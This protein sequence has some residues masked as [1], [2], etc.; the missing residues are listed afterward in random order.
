MKSNERAGRLMQVAPPPPLGSMLAAGHVLYEKNVWIRMTR[1]GQPEYGK[2][3]PPRQ[4]LGSRP[5]FFSTLCIGLPVVVAPFF[6]FSP[7]AQ[8]SVRSQLILT[9]QTG[10][11]RI[12][13]DLNYLHA[14]PRLTLFDGVHTL[15]QLSTGLDV[16]LV[17]IWFS[18]LLRPPKTPPNSSS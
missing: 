3:P 13:Q 4:R 8:Q 11:G 17:L 6:S 10:S 2:P 18:S 14:Q 7:P 1:Y 5:I 15:P 9:D 12:R 16:S